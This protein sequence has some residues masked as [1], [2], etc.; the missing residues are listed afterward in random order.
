LKQKF[1]VSGTNSYQMCRPQGVI[2]L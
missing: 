1:L 2:I